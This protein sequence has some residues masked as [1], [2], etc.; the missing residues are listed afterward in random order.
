[1]ASALH[2]SVVNVSS[3]LEK[4]RQLLSK[5]QIESEIKAL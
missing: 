1:M 2:V 5:F 3:V 4:Q